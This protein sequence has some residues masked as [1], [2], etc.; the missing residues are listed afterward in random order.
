MQIDVFIDDLGSEGELL[1][2]A[3]C[4]YI[5]GKYKVVPDSVQ[6]WAKKGRKV[7]FDHFPCP[8]RPRN[9]KNGLLA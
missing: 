4:K 9:V 5:S 1:L 8:D 6:N 3:T 7:E 2:S